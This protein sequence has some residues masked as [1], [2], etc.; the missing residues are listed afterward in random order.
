MARQAAR[1][2]GIPSDR[3]EF[4][5]G[6]DLLL[7]PAQNGPPLNYFIYPYAEV[8]GKPVSSGEIEATFSFE[9]VSDGRK[10]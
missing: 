5:V 2:W 1:N 10:R 3:I 8:D 4:T 6:R 7:S 9:R